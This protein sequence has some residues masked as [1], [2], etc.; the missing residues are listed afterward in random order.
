MLEAI[1]Y[2]KLL[3][4]DPDGT[5]GMSCLDETDE[6][7]NQDEEMTK[8][9]F[10]AAIILIHVAGLRRGRLIAL[11]TQGELNK[12]LLVIES[13]SDQLFFELLMSKT[14]HDHAHHESYFIRRFAQVKDF[15]ILAEPAHF[16]GKVK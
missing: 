5:H 4:V 6:Y 10:Q 3:L 8:L 13:Q 11:Q 7:S 12:N 16:F 1:P 9:L 14:S 15:L 2:C